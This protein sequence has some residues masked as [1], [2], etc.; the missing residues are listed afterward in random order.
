M[1]HT[2]QS[3][4]DIPIQCFW[5]GLASAEDPITDRYHSLD[6]CGGCLTEVFAMLKPGINSQRAGGFLDRGLLVHPAAW[7]RG[8]ASGPGSAPAG[9]SCPGWPRFADRVLPWRGS[10]TAAL[11]DECPSGSS[12]QPGTRLLGRCS[13]VP[14]IVNVAI[15]GQACLASASAHVFE[16]LLRRS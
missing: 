8:A 13:G 4:L 11:I 3:I 1:T 12:A 14:R 16:K 2:D 7:P 5:S 9:P 15:T 6:F 10:R